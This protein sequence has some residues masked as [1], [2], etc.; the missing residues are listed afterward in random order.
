MSRAYDKITLLDKWRLVQK[1]VSDPGLSR[2]A[3]ACGFH[4]IDLYNIRLD[5]AWPSYDTLAA[6]TGANRRTV[7]TA[8]KRLLASEYFEVDRGSGRRSNYYRPNFS[9]INSV[10]Q[11]SPDGDQ[12]TTT[13][14]A[15]TPPLQG[16]EVNSS[17]P[18]TSYVPVAPSVGDIEVSP[19]S[20]GSSA[21]RATSP[22][23]GAP[24]GFEKFWQAY[25]KKEGRKAAL[26]AYAMAL[27]KGDVTP[28]LLAVKAAQYAHAKGDQDPKWIKMPKTWLDEECWLEDPQPSGQKKPAKAAKKNHPGKTTRDNRSTTNTKRAKTAPKAKS[29]PRRRKKRRAARSTQ[30]IT[31]ARA[32]PIY[33]DFLGI[34]LDNLAAAT[35]ISASVLK[36]SCSGKAGMPNDMKR[37]LRSLLIEA[38]LYLPDD[39]PLSV[40]ALQGWYEQWI[41]Y[42]PLTDYTWRRPEHYKKDRQGSGNT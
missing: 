7:I 30:P 9:L 8:V 17:P 13:S 4:L 35:G 20:A 26:K 15:Q 18:N 19:R 14:G 12:N 25:P 21:R 5:R 3:V 31:F 11:Q 33:C 37:K 28:E 29:K 22:T 40:D 27:Q 32:V 2:C 39:K 41:K 34:T 10:P 16:V 6:L 36:K 23:R 42:K 1:V 38:V 24:P